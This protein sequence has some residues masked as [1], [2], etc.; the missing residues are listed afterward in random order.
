[1]QPHIFERFYRGRTHRADGG[2][3]PG[4]GLGLSIVASIVQAHGWTIGVESVAGSGAR[5]EIQTVIGEQ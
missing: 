4:S 5:F 3:I 1:V 2:E